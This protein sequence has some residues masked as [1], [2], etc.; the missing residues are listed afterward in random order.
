MVIT[1]IVRLLGLDDRAGRRVDIDLDSIIQMDSI[2][3]HAV[4]AI[5]LDL[6]YGGSRI[7]FEGNL[8]C[9]GQVD[10]RMQG[11]RADY[12]G[13]AA[14]IVIMVIVVVLG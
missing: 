6:G 7:P 11:R 10:G 4:V 13:N 5:E 14:P 8:L 9:S 3:E 12:R 2:F 1:V